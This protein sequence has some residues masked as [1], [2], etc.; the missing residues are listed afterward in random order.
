VKAPGAKWHPSAAIRALPTIVVSWL[1]FMAI[2]LVA[3]DMTC[4]GAPQGAGTG[5]AGSGSGSGSAAGLGACSLAS[6]EADIGNVS[7]LTTVLADLASGNYLAAIGT[8]IAQVGQQEVG[9]VVLA[10]EDFATAQAAVGGAGSGSAVAPA[11]A[12][13]RDAQVLLQRVRDVE[14]R[15]GI[16]R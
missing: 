8:L 10:I 5:S 12:A 2:G 9:C 1:M 13:A 6:L 3:I 15:Y 14:A 16:R 7:L 11:T 4:C